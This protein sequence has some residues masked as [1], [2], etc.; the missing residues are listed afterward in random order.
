VIHRASHP[1]HRGGE[2][3]EDRLADQEVPDIEFSDLGQ[4]SDPLRSDEVEAMA[5]VN[6]EPCP[7]GKVCA[8]NDAREFTFSRRGIAGG[9]R[10][11]PCSGMNLDHRR[12]HRGG[13]L[14]L[15]GLGGD[16]QR[17]TDTRFGELTDNPT[18]AVPLTGC[19]EPA[20]GCPLLP[21]LRHDTGGM[22]TNLA[23]DSYH[24]RSRRHFKIERLG[25]ALLKPSDIVINDVPAILAQMRGDTVSACGNRN[26]GGFQ[27]IGMPPAA[28]VTHGRDVINVDA[29]TNG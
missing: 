10:I 26:L 7:H 2:T 29:E 17:D 9:K 15:L 24:F 18:Q 22:R 1:A 20:F 25:D 21:P 3:V 12:A 5:S 23:R 6:L 16:E 14:D 28:R 27:R 4:R 19:I 8:A 11:A 13:S